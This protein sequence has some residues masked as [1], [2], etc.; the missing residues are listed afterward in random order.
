MLR[1]LLRFSAFASALA[2]ALLIPACGPS[3]GGKAGKAK[4]A[5]VTNVTDPF[6]DIAQAG[7]MK[8]G[9]DFDV[10]VIFKQPDTL[11]VDSQMKEVKN[12]LDL[13][14]KGLSVSVI[15]PGEQSAKL[16]AIAQDLPSNNFMTMDNDAPESGRLCYVGVDNLEA[17]R[18]V[19]RLVKSA[20]PDGGTVALFIGAIDSDNGKK[21][22]A[23]VLSELADVP[24]QEVLDEVSRPKAFYRETYGKYTLHRK[25]A[26]TDG[27]AK[28]KAAANAGDELGKLEGKSNLCFVGLYAYNPAKILEAAR[29]KG[30]VGKIKI[31]GFDEDLV[32]LDGI[33]K[34]EIVGSV[35]QDPY[36]YGYETVK[37]LRHVIDGK[38][39]TQLPQKPTAYSL[40]TQ[41]GKTIA[42]CKAEKFKKASDYAA[43]VQAAYKAGKGK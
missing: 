31:V 37:W 33:D 21:R 40:I 9:E 23:G 30:L 10:Q 38:D 26:I 19:G 36:G 41:D 27:G 29:Q 35:S 5:I 7:A 2:L 18:E 8:G 4:V 14:L 22:V 3:G 16:K 6:W 43:T 32:T 11:S 1:N 17:G 13:G 42:G 15:N 12:V 28:D 24:G 25:E 34:G 39:K 20:L